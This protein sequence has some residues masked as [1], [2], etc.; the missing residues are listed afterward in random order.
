M[1]SSNSIPWYL[2]ATVG[3]LWGTGRR[4]CSPL[5]GRARLHRATGA[6]TAAHPGIGSRRNPPRNQG[7]HRYGSQALLK[8]PGPANVTA[9]AS[10]LQF[11]LQLSAKPC[12]SREI[13]VRLTH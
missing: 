8:R 5:H 11:L 4:A 2:L 9:Q 10:L 1:P 7:V 13:S 6:P 12:N 3:A